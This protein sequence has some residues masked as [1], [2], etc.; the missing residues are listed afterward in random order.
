MQVKMKLA[1]NIGIFATLGDYKE[2]L[3]AQPREKYR[4]Y[5]EIFSKVYNRRLERTDIQRMR[6]FQK[7]VYEQ[8]IFAGAASINI[9][10]SRTIDPRRIGR[11]DVTS[12]DQYLPIKPKLEL[13]EYIAIKN[14]LVRYIE[15]SIAD[16]KVIADLLDQAYKMFIEIDQKTNT[17]IPEHELIRGLLYFTFPDRQSDRNAFDHARSILRDLADEDKKYKSEF[18]YFYCWA[19]RRL[20]EFARA[21]VRLGEAIHEYPEDPRF[22]HGRALNIYS[23]LSN[24]AKKKECKYGIA[25]G[26]QDLENAIRYYELTKKESIKLIAACYN[27]LAYFWVWRCQ[28][29]DH[30]SPELKSYLD[31]AR[32]AL[33]QL[34]RFMPKDRWDPTYPEYFET[35]SSIEYVEFQQMKI[36]QKSAALQIK[37]LESALANLTTAYTLYPKPHYAKSKAQMEEELDILRG[38]S[39]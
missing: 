26:I 29:I 23:W 20:G 37:K 8:T 25:D 12:A 7:L 39:T 17:F 34:I 27:D 38:N 16:P 30:Q 4:K 33:N 18:L 22:Y 35:E 32:A 31:Q 15:T 2:L 36:E 28:E 24:E 3:N 10:N 14:I 1:K 21:D 5:Y 11:D 6:I 13:E 9:S 19:A